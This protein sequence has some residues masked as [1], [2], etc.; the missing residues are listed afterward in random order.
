MKTFRSAALLL[1][2]PVFAACASSS[3]VVNHTIPPKYSIVPAK[4]VAVAGRSA[5]GPPYDA[6]DDFLNLLITKLRRR[7]LYEI[8]GLSFLLLPAGTFTMGCTEGD[9]ECTDEEKPPHKVTISKSFYMAFTPATNFQ[10]QK[11]VDAGPCHGTADMT[12]RLDPVVNVSWDDARDFCA[13]A[14]GRLPTE[15][16]WEYAARGGTNDWRFPWGNDAGS[17]N[18]NFA[19]TPGRHDQYIGANLEPSPAA[20]KLLGLIYP[21]GGTS[22]VGTFD[23]NGLGLYDMVGNA[24]QWTADWAG[25]YA[26]AAAT[27]PTGPATGEQHVLRGG[28]WAGTDAAGRVSMRYSAAANIVRNT[29]GFRCARDQ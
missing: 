23:K 28:S 2:L 26:G 8:K 12:K 5:G 15:A 17:D 13:W 11:C 20:Q 29:V 14:G 18:A 16:E 3:I 21:H 22:P 6:E 27:D 4:S 24:V 9:D 7:G 10:Y 19:V 1:A 25:G